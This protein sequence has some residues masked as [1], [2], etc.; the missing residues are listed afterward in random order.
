MQRSLPSLKTSLFVI[1]WPVKSE[2][3]ESLAKLNYAC[4]YPH[5]GSKKLENFVP[6]EEVFFKYCSISPKIKLIELESN[7]F[8]RFLD[9][10]CIIKLI[11]HVF[12]CRWIP[13]RR[14]W[15][16]SRP[17]T[18]TSDVRRMGTNR[19]RHCLRF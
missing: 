14:W 3:D 5:T 11:V 15:S 7:F 2:M 4:L 10:V 18:I 17:P 9:P 12:N 16:P 13:W 1:C 6:K 19:I 8:P